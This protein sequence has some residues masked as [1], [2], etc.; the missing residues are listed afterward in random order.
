MT[1]DAPQ[2]GWYPNP[3]G[4]GGLRWWSGVGWT[5]YTR[6]NPAGQ[7]TTVLGDEPSEQPTTRLEEPTQVQSEVPATAAWPQ[8]GGT[9]GDPA[10]PPQPP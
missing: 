2:A 5:E 7:E 8:P 1:N 4:S 9:W 6:P 3:D 10:T